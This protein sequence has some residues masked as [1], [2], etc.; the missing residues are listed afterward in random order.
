MNWKFLG[1]AAAAA[2]FSTQAFADLN[3]KLYVGHGINGSDLGLPTALPVDICSGGAELLSNVPFKTITATPLTLPAG[4]YRIEVRLA[5]PGTCTG[6]LAVAADV[7]LGVAENATAIA[8]LT[9]QGTPTI[10]KFVND[11]RPTNGQT[12]IVVRHAAAAGDVNVLLRQ[13]H[14]NRL[15]LNLRNSDQQTRVEKA[16]PWLVAIYTAD[17]WRLLFHANLN[18]SPNVANFA[19]AVGSPNRKTFEVLLQSIKLN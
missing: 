3:A 6:A 14:T 19:Y 16:G 2:L 11:V 13:G 5:S 4:I 12:R 10:T 18:L 1:L 7:S 17:A 15:I 9:E 8:H